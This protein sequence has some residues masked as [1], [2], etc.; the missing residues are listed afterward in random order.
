VIYSLLATVFDRRR[1]WLILQRKS[2]A[3][4]LGS[5]TVP[6]TDA[7]RH[8]S[9]FPACEL[10]ARHSEEKELFAINRNISPRDLY[11]LLKQTEYCPDLEPQTAGI[12]IDG[13]AAIVVYWHSE[14]SAHRCRLHPETPPYEVITIWISRLQASPA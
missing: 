13:Q 4:G 12:G 7:H 2:T 1:V 10:E 14:R 9:T 8:L 3:G 11:R 5:N 6:T